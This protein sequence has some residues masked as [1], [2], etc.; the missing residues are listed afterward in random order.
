MPLRNSG[1]M[2]GAGS[3]SFHS[4]WRIFLGSVIFAL[5]TACYFLTPTYVP[6]SIPL[7]I[8]ALIASLIAVTRAPKQFWLFKIAFFFIGFFLAVTRTEFTANE[9][10]ERNQFFTGQAIVEDIVERE[11]G[12]IRLTLVDL[13]YDNKGR[14]S[15]KRV[16]LFARTSIPEN[17]MAGDRIKFSAVLERPFGKLTPNG[18]DFARAA[19]FDDIQAT[20]YVTTPVQTIEQKSAISVN[21]IRQGYADEIVKT[22]PGEAGALA[23]ALLVGRR[24][25]LSQQTTENLR[26]SGLAHMLAISGLHMGIFI[27]AA[28]FIFE[29]LFLFAPIRSRHLSG[30]KLAALC[31]WGVSIIYLVL[32]GMS[33]ATIRAFVVASIAIVAVLLD[34]RVVSLRSISIAALII[35]LISPYAILSAGFQMSFAATIALVSVYELINEKRQQKYE[36][37]EAVIVKSNNKFSVFLNSVG[38]FILYTSLTTV[39]AQ[40]AILPI[41]LFHFQTIAV[42]GILSNLIAVPILLFIIVPSA[43]LSMVL[44]VF[45]LEWISLSVLTWGLEQII[46]IA[47][48]V[49]AIEWSRVFVPPVYSY[50]LLATLSIGAGVVTVRKSWIIT[51]FLLTLYCILP[52]ALTVPEPSV[53]ISK[54]GH[55]IAYEEAPDEIVFYTV[56]Q[57]GLAADSYKKQ[58]GKPPKYKARRGRR[59]CDEY[60]C[61]YQLTGRK[62][63]INVRKFPALHE[64]CVRATY[65]IIPRRWQRYCRGESLIIIKEMLETE[66]PLFIYEEENSRQLKWANSSDT[67]RRWSSN[68]N[69]RDK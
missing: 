5:G 47:E 37:S 13:K 42:A 4:E 7:I 27:G 28:F 25:Y 66:G 59:V 10:I 58:W 16:R 61:L 18:Y 62:T 60:A 23:A 36:T 12:L 14:N 49:A 32:S 34:R 8:I 21:R 6:L 68:Y 52:F 29:F 54:S 9:F 43:F 69:Q 51:V 35:L 40:V 46:D 1:I 33:V 19:Y 57:N 55:S 48:F 31:A 38:K 24:S 22:I 65:V 30:R 44:A 45:G 63:V 26:A 17:L 64:A 11:T 39:V 41:A 67:N 56:R 20:G 53:I 50:V 2:P 15:L 3:L